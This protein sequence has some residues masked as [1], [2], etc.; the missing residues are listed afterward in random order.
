MQEV[1]DACLYEPSKFLSLSQQQE[2][3]LAQIPPK[4]DSVYATSCGLLLNEVLQAPNV[5]LDAL[6]RLLNLTLELD[7]GTLSLDSRNCAAILYAIRTAVRI[8]SFMRLIL[9]HA[10]WLESGEY[11]VFFRAVDNDS[12]FFE[13]HPIKNDFY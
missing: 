6:Q 2:P 13:K 8:E 1:I 3:T 10:Q 4:D 12:Y 7:G 9:Q 11:V 5:L